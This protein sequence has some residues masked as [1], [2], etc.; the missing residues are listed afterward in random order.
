LKKHTLKALENNVLR[1][2]SG[3]ENEDGRRKRRQLLNENL[4]LL[5]L[6]S[7]Y[8]SCEGMEFADFCVPLVISYHF[9][10]TLFNYAV[11]TTEDFSVDS[12]RWLYTLEWKEL[13]TKRSRY[14]PNG[15]HGLLI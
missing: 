14:D 11:S 3:A 4:S 7:L 6:Y 12:D 5:H 1:R 8:S 2:I 13:Q 10:H 15:G 9:G